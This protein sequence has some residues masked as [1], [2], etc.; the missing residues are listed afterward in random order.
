MT[1]RN[2]HPAAPVDHVHV[3]DLD[4]CLDLIN[5][6]ELTDGIPED[7]IPTMDDAIAWL[8]SRS[9]AHEDALRTEAGRDPDAWLERVR[10]ARHAL[11]EV[12][13]STVEGRSADPAAL[14]VVNEELRHR[15]RA[16]L[17]ATLAGIAVTHR[18]D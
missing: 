13:D 3:A 6:V 16:E 2:T 8:G 10:A 18:H 4:A 5:T 1:T 7:H 17:R 15:T 11:R 9:L 14:T 12:W